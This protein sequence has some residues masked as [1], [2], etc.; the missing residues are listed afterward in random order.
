MPCLASQQCWPLLL[1]LSGITRI[2][3]FWETLYQ[4][5]YFN[6]Y[7]QPISLSKNAGLQSFFHKDS[8]GDF[9]YTNHI[10]Q[11]VLLE[12]M[13]QQLRFSLCKTPITCYYYQP[14][15]TKTLSKCSPAT[16]WTM[17]V[18]SCEA[19]LHTDGEPQL[20]KR[21]FSFLVFNLLLPDALMNNT[22]QMDR[23]RD[24]QEFWMS[25]FADKWHFNP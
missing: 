14:L 2:S 23:V 11:N 17:P 13:I 9:T 5:N 1:F 16:H 7:L 18:F 24:N 4:L 25:T 6:G 19:W 3:R 22:A 10:Y 8:T 12:G 15:L 20:H 21:F